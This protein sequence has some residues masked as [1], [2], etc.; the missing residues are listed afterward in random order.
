MRIEAQAIGRE[1]VR[2]IELYGGITSDLCVEDYQRLL[3]DARSSNLAGIMLVS[4]TK[5]M[6]WSPLLT[7]DGMPPLV[8]AAQPG[9]LR[10]VSS[11][12]FDSTSLI[13]RAL[14]YFV[15]RGRRRVAAIAVWSDSP[16]S[17]FWRYFAAAAEKRGLVS[18]P[19]W[20]QG[21]GPQWPDAA[22]STAQLLM[23]AEERPDALLIADD[24]LVEPATAGLVAAGRGR[25]SDL[26]VV[27]HC[28]FPYRPTA[29][30]PV[31]FV[32]FD[33]RQYL[34]AFIDTLDLKRRGGKVP[35]DVSLPARYDD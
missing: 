19:Y 18:H 20:R 16:D 32:G 11:I 14:D 13:D 24:S 3:H 6:E 2:S 21:A 8:M 10:G 5:F 33:V 29:H 34:T 1:G 17:H 31:K 28:N 27:A 26:D 9:A 15:Q 12:M 25:I 4:P 22:N 23:H 30:V 35:P 7:E